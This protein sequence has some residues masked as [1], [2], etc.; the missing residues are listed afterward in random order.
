MGESP[1]RSKLASRPVASVAIHRATGGCEAYT[2][3]KQAVKIQLRNLLTIAMPTCS[4]GG[5]QHSVTTEIAKG[6][7]RS[8]ESLAQ[9]MFPRGFLRNLGELTI[10]ASWKSGNADVKGD[11]RCP[12]TDG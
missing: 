6:G 9:G 3:R 11:R 2:A 1:I 10:S 4:E 7:P 12:S 5:R 8:P